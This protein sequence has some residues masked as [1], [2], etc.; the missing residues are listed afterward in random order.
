MHPRHDSGQDI[1]IAAFTTSALSEER[2]LI[3]ATGTVDKTAAPRQDNTRTALR[4]ASCTASLKQ[5]GERVADAGTAL[6]SLR[7][8]EVLRRT[9]NLRGAPGDHTGRLSFKSNLTA[10]QSCDGRV[11]EEAI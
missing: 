7:V 2:V 5:L 8:T 6:N 9:S 4:A 10:V 1:E 11:A 3:L